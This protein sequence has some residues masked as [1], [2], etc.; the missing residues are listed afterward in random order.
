MTSTTLH[1]YT[2]AKPLSEVDDLAKYLE[3]YDLEYVKLDELDAE[4][5]TL[6]AGD[7]HTLKSL[8]ASLLRLYITRKLFLCSLLAIPAIGGANDYARWSPAVDL[9][10]HNS[11][12]FDKEVTKLK[13]ALLED[14]GSLSTENHSPS[15]SLPLSL[16]FILS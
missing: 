8:K 9:L 4:V 10:Q 6:E 3:I 16:S 11:C 1:A 7:T 15:L 14:Q 2:S 12:L 5:D 13:H